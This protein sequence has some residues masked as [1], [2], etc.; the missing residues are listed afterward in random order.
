MMLT[1]SNP[2][3]LAI[4]GNPG[5]SKRARRI[6]QLK[7][8]WKKRTRPGGRWAGYKA[9]IRPK[10]GRKLKVRGKGR[11]WAWTG[12]KGTV[13]LHRKGKLVA[14]NPTA[15]LRR[16]IITPI[17]QLPQH[18][19]GLTRGPV[20]KNFAFATGG[21]FAGL[22]GG[23]ILQR[24]VIGAVAGFMPA[25]VN[26]ILGMGIVQRVVGAS[27]AL[28]AG[29][30]VSMAVRKPQD[31]VN[32]I[33]G[34]AAAALIEAVFPGRVAGALARLP[35]IGRFA[36][37]YA[38]PVHGLAGVYG[39]DELAAYVES[40]AYQGV[41]AY[42]ESPAYQGVGA[43]VESPAYQGVGGAMDNA[44]AG[45]GYDPNQLAGGHLN[46]LGAMGSNM[47]SHLD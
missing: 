6:S 24:T 32:F 3:N 44:V 35:V 17:T 30:L 5:R 19:R 27:F 15:R 46:G 42:V 10:A 45:L 29:G 34:T 23:S 26:N 7:S 41:G 1:L 8:R 39:S 38:S 43:Y 20:V 4:V 28:V 40:P 14:T 12:R 2:L 16:T 22:I 11:R 31:K 47:A 36:A 37:P 33:T 21:A 13:S 9:V 18:L 25:A